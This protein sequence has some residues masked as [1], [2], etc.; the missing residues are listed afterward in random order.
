[1][2]FYSFLS[3]V[4]LAL[5]CHPTLNFKA[6]SSLMSEIR[7][8]WDVSSD[9]DIRHYLARERA[10]DFFPGDEELDM[11]VAKRAYEM[12]LYASDVLDGRVKSYKIIKVEKVKPKEYPLY[13]KSVTRVE[14]AYLVRVRYKLRKRYPLSRAEIE[15]E[16]VWGRI[17]RKWYIVP[18]SIV[19][20]P[21]RE[22]G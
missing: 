1:M 19:G 13:F 4:L 5:L 20:E 12:M 11:F 9:V 10:K 8:F 14:E 7:R 21:R 3:L 16:D 6:P 18:F 15:T 22:G 17:G 2:K